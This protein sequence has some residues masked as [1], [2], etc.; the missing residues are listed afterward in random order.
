MRLKFIDYPPEISIAEY[1]NL[2]SKL[3]G[4]LVENDAVLSVYQM[5]SVRHPGISDL[6]IICVFKN[7]SHCRKNYRNELSAQ[8][9]NILTHGIFG[10]EEKD[11]AKSM[12]YNLISNLKFLG[13][14]NLGL[15]RINIITSDEVK[16]QIALEYLVKML[17]TINTQVKLKIVKLRAFLLLA[18]AV[19]FDLQLLGEQ[20]GKLH[21]LVKKVIA[22]REK[23]YSKRPS[24][25]EMSDLVHDFNHEL[26]FFLEAQLFKSVFYLPSQT[27]KLPGNFVIQ[28]DDGF[29]I[30][31]KGM[32]LPNQL[33]FLGKK[34]INLQYKLNQFVYYLPFQI[35]LKESVHYERFHFSKQLVYTNKEN[36]PH[37]I[38]LT[39][40]LSFY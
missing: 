21:D 38:P 5:G 36:Y 17:L 13:G 2:K 16:T 27:C 20:K 24:N 37:F 1:K 23:W 28:K 22:Y 39:T 30:M 31:H 7:E 6:D 15:D 9:K 40:S 32:V 19:E 35:P 10:I 3:T 34:Y 26:K 14:E 25:R 18:K 4:Q 12:S 29:S 11:L 33:G 8:E